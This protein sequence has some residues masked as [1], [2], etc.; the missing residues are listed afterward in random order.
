M[1]R[2]IFL[3][4]ALS[5]STANAASVCSVHDG[6]TLR[7]C[8]GQRIR[9]F[10]IDAPELKQPFGRESGNYL[11][12]LV[13]HKDVGLACKGRSFKRPVCRVS[14]GGLDVERAMVSQGWAYDFPK[15]SYGFY[16]SE[17]RM[18]QSRGVGVWSKPKQVKPWVWRKM[19][20]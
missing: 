17:E 20:N 3:I 7:L 10:G 1:L 18:A 6:D 2:I 16:K 4:A 5:L 8:S 19:K 12:G 11:R 13:L 9:L 15:Y 14:V